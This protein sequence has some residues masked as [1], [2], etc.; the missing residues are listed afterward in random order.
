[1]GRS[2]TCKARSLRANEHLR[3][4]FVLIITVTNTM[5]KYITI[6]WLYSNTCEKHRNCSQGLVEPL[7]HTRHHY[8]CK[9]ASHENEN[10]YIGLPNTMWNHAIKQNNTHIPITQKHNK[11]RKPLPGT[12]QTKHNPASKIWSLRLQG[13]PDLGFWFF[14]C[15]WFLLMLLLL[16]CMFAC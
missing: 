8:F 15:F 7:K 9:I 5:L 14:W 3:E 16:S 6:K 13:P 12:K 1:M 11:E 2:L 10:Q 4:S